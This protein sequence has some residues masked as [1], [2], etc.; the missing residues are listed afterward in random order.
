LRGVADAIAEDVLD[1]SAE[2]LAIPFDLSGEAAFDGDAAAANLS[3]QSAIADDLVHDVGGTRDLG[4]LPGGAAFDEVHLHDIADER[5]DA[6]DVALDAIERRLAVGGGSGELDGELEARERG[7][8]F[9]GDV[10]KEPALTCDQ[11]LQL[12]GHLIEGTAELTNLVLTLALHP[13]GEI[14]LTEERD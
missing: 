1:G 7:T 8:K 5:G 12:V 4:F 13:R 2:Q 6:V 14:S 3:F 9:V 10:A 11:G